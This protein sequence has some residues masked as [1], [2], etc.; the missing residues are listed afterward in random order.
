MKT[1]LLKLLRLTIA[2]LVIS[3]ISCK[4]SGNSNDSDSFTWTWNGTNYTGNFKEAFTQS[5]SLG[6]LII[7]GTGSTVY[8]AGSGPRISLNSLNAGVYTLGGGI[9]N[10]IMF[11][12]PN[13][14]NLQSTTGTLTIT[15]N[16]NSK[17]SGNF[18]ATLVNGVG[19]NN[20]LTGSFINIK[21]SF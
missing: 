13:G 3:A 21:I 9:T 18:S 4:K 15:S 8:S 14:N 1:R 6:P 20:S 17:L 7:G 5:L 12:D 16:S 11:I 10:S 19:Q 2:I